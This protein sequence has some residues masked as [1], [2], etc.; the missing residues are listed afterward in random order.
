MPDNEITVVDFD[1]DQHTLPSGGFT[2]TLGPLETHDP[3]PQQDL[4]RHYITSQWMHSSHLADENPQW[5]IESWLKQNPHINEL[6][7]EGILEIDQV[8]ED[9]VEYHHRATQQE[10]FAWRI[11]WSEQIENQKT[12][13]SH[14]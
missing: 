7:C 12:V 3:P 5:Q 13:Y 4:F 11:R 1:P 14:P 10:H 6:Y 9:T 2:I 8:S